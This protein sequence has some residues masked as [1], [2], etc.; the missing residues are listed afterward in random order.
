MICPEQLLA[1]YMRMTSHATNPR[2]DLV[3]A[4]PKVGGLASCLPGVCER[5]G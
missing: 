5:Y 4:G 2:H 1:N 3:V